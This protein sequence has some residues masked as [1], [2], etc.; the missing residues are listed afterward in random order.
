MP[1]RL[2]LPIA[3]LLS[4]CQL[5]YLGPPVELKNLNADVDTALA[6]CADDDPDESTCGGYT[7][8][9]TTTLTFALVNHDANRDI[10]RLQSASVTLG[11]DLLDAP[12]GCDAD[13]YTLAAGESSEVIEIRVDRGFQ[14]ADDA[15]DDLDPVRQVAAVFLGCQAED[16]SGEGDGIIRVDDADAEIVDVTL[17]LEGLLDDGE[18]WEAEAST[19]L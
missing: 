6:S 17:R 14:D 4:A 3:A 2:L 15:C 18:S 5:P 11:G 19:S 8:C 16:G 9:D 12:S 13:P 7:R 1:R 10:D